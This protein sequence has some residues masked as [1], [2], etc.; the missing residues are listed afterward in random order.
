MAAESQPKTTSIPPVLE[1]PP[2]SLR[3]CVLG[4]EEEVL[5]SPHSN[6]A[7][8]IALLGDEARKVQAAQR[9]TGF[10]LKD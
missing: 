3:S 10:L 4:G 1:S 5:L 8:N 7:Q 2:L 6:D 9:Q